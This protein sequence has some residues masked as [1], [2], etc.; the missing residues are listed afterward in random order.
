LVLRLTFALGKIVE[1][2]VI[3]NPARLQQLDLA[4]LGS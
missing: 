3:A 4:T 2:D 1:I